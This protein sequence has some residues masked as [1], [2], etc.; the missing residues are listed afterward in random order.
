MAEDAVRFRARA[1]QCRALADATHDL[2]AQESL[3]EIADDLDA[4][5]LKIEKEERAYGSAMG[6]KRSLDRPHQAKP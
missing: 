3:R 2:E 5:A 4:E 1:S 6:R